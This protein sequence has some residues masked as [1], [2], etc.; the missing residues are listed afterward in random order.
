MLLKPHILSHAKFSPAKAQGHEGL[1]GTFILEN[2]C[3]DFKKSL[4]LLL[5]QR[6]KR[7]TEE[8]N[9]PQLDLTR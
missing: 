6:R 1:G 3:K 8:K 7:E 9:K 4:F 5:S 2:I